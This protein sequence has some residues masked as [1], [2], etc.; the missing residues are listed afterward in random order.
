[1]VSIYI[2]STAGYSGKSLVTLGLGLRMR[3]DGIS[4][5]FM[6]PF[7]RSPV[8]EDGVLMD[9]DASFMKKTLGLDDPVGTICP[10]VYTHDLYAE[11][12]R[13]R[14]RDLATAVMKAH[15]ALSKGRD[16][17]LVGGARDVYDGAFIGIS[18][19]RLIPKMDAKVLMV[20][21]FEGEVCVDCLLAV[22]ELLGDRLIGAV[23]NK[24]P[25]EGVDFV[26]GMAGPF[27]KKKGIPL[28]GVIPADKLLHSISVGQLAESLGGR[29]LCAED[30]LDE[31]VENFLIGAMD[32][33][34]ALKYFRKTPNKAVVTGGHRSDI[35]LAAL[36]TSTRCL[37]LT[38]DM[39]PNNLI[40][41]K[42][43][44]AGVPIIV[45]RHDTLTT[46]ERFEAVLGKVRI[47]E[48]RKVE[49]ARWMME[50]HFD[51]KAFY[52]LAGLRKP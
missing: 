1:M 52:R 49:S 13:G 37:V 9:G 25:A 48:E 47:R 26:R 38:G 15:K 21:P 4:A 32:A 31:L 43:R 50:E 46:V 8:V 34:S 40:I 18:A 14:G 44:T 17:L 27:L 29:V 51:Y 42:A 33:E 41:A 24:V 20:D 12:L 2:V 16:A 36:E 35:Q 3:A 30:R 6:K 10:V 23:V 39:L 11:A 22:K 45:V 7:G 5:G 19:L 28:L